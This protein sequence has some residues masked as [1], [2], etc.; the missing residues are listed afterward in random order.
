[1]KIEIIFLFLLVSLI[2][3]SGCTKPDK[4]QG[5]YNVTV[6]EKLCN[7]TYLGVP[8]NLETCWNSCRTLGTRGDAYNKYIENLKEL[9]MNET[10]A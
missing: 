10:N 4:T 9:R 3:L 2:F 8:E 1:M 7:D 5:V 6:C